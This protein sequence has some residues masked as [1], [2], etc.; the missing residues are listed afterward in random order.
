M[1]ALSKDNYR[2]LKFVCKKRG[3]GDIPEG[4]VFA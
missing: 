2:A 3:Q 1:I 4:K